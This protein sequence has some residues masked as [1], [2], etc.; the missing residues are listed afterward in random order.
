MG[1]VKTRQSKYNVPHDTSTPSKYL[2]Q[3]ITH[4]FI[5]KVICNAPTRKLEWKILEAYFIATMKATLNE[6]IEFDLFYLSRNSIY[7][8]IR[9]PGA[10]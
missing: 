6:Q 5:L 4:I 7:C 2:N 10:L 1:N 8:I 9:P 3:N